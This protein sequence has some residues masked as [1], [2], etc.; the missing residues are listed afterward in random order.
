VDGVGEEK[1][2]RKGIRKACVKIIRE[3]EGRKR[4]R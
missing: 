1:N 4:I 3:E 2:W